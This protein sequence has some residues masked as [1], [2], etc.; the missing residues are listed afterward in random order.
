MPALPLHYSGWQAPRRGSAGVR[1]PI[2]EELARLKHYELIERLGEGGMGVVYRARDERLGR[3]VA[4]KILPKELAADEDRSRRFEREARIASSLSHPGIATLYDIDRD[5]DTTFL[6]MELV[7]GRTLRR[8]LEDG[9][10]P[11]ERVIECGAQVA[12]A[13][14]DAHRKGVVHR[15]LK[16]E[17]VMAADSGY[18]KVLDFGIARV[19][20]PPEEESGGSSTRTPTRTWATRAGALIGTVTYMSPEQA[21]GEQVDPRSDIFSFGVLLYE[22]TAGQPP[23]QGANDV[24]TAQAILSSEPA[25]LTSLR[26]DVPPGLQLVIRR[27][28]AKRPEE[29]Y[30]SAV[31]LAEDLG[32]LRRD[33]LSGQRS[34]IRLHAMRGIPGRGRR[35]AIAGLIGAGLTVAAVATWLAVS[36]IAPE[37]EAVATPAQMRPEPAGVLLPAVAGGKSRVIVGFFENLTGNADADWLGRGL[38][39]MLTTDLSGSDEIEVI[40]TQRLYDLLAMSGRGQAEKLDRSTATELARWAG[41]DLVISGSVFRFGDRYRV[42]AQAY[43]THTG[44]I[45]AAQKVEGTE[46][47]AL[48][49]QLAAGL[50][51]GLRLGVP[52]RRGPSGVTTESEDAYR[53]YVRGRELYDRLVF[54]D[55]AEQFDQAVRLDPGFARARLRAAQSRYLA[56]ERDAAREDLEKLREDVERLPEPE[57]MLALGLHDFFVAGDRK[58]GGE[59]FD[60]LVRQF[61]RDKDAHV[62][63]GL[64]LRDV[65]GDPLGA[66]REL[67]QALEQDPNN[68]PAI[69]AL[70]RELAA[71]GAGTDAEAMLRG[72]ILRNP[73]A[74]DSLER[75]IES[76]RSS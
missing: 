55:A 67:R 3:T 60:R 74:A 16:P 41:A 70:A 31:E 7:E 34:A 61:P 35:W 17:N 4:L 62:W 59:H 50:R 48:V 43:D 45:V 6:T 53:L 12:D 33:S 25:P 15:D 23:F 10:L 49:D 47:L 38:P 40:A 29:R 26:P 19:E 18:F 71:L 30:P 75:L 2:L 52:A 11:I 54:E 69:A 56:G 24:A 51:S 68:L 58:A 57:R 66:T 44:A 76:L 39:E 27:C 28:L 46:V 1:E 9:P 32:A 36:P 72:A 64:A 13:L 42:D 63:W 22:L 14:A 37:P 65:G 21:L 73:E 20:E 8:L 5:G